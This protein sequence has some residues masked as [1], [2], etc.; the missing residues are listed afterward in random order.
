[1]IWDHENEA[2]LPKWAQQRLNRLRL[3]NEVLKKELRDR[4]DR[5]EEDA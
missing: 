2:T 4:T 3:E 5:Q 1:M